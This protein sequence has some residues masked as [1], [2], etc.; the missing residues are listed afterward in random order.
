MPPRFLPRAQLAT[1]LEHLPERGFMT[2]A[3]Q[4][5]DNAI[6]YR[7]IESVDK[8][9]HGM[10]VE[11]QPGSYRIL[12]RDDERCFAWANGPQALKPLTFLPEEILW[13]ARRDAQGALVFE[14]PSRHP[15]PTA[16]LGVRSC[17]IAAHKLQ[18]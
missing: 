1:L 5:I 10:G 6:L 8:L 13:Q 11:Q 9:P 12:H 7:P 17:D 16:V 18:Q 2:I 3:P 14:A 15:K 4:L